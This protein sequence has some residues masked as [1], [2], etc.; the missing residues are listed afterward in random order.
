MWCSDS[1]EDNAVINQHI[2]RI[3][4]AKRIFKE[5]NLYKEIE[6]VTNLMKSL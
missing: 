3:I 6:R 4:K 1:E 5:R 2:R